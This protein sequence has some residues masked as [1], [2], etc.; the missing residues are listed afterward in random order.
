M[1]PYVSTTPSMINRV[2]VLFALVSM[3]KNTC[4]KQLRGKMAFDSQFQRSSVHHDKED[5]AVAAV[6]ASASASQLMG[7]KLVTAYFHS[8][9]QKTANLDCNEMHVGH[10]RAHL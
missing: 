3:K 2:S 10:L 1:N 4:N 9:A 6:G 8:S 7:E 5:M